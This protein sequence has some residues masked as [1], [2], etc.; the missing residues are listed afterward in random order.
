[1]RSLL[2]LTGLRASAL[3]STYGQENFSL[4]TARMVFSGNL[5]CVRISLLQTVETITGGE[6]PPNPE[7]IAGSRG[8]RTNESDVKME[9]SEIIAIPSIAISAGTLFMNIPFRQRVG[10]NSSGIH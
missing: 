4:N 3:V 2:G 8:G 10:S 9:A 7:L 6:S 5:K 1:M